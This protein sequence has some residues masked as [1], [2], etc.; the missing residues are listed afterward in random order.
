MLLVPPACSCHR[1]LALLRGPCQY[2]CVPAVVGRELD[3][4]GA[5]PAIP[6]ILAVLTALAIHT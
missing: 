3:T 2:L 4:R 5:Q 6:P 1:L